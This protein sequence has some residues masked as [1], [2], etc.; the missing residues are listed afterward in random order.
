VFQ[1]N[2]DI[3]TGSE[4]RQQIARKLMTKIVNL[5]SVKLE[6]GSPMINMYL[7]GNP[8]HY[9]SHNFGNCYWQA[10]VTTARSSWVTSAATDVSGKPQDEAVKLSIVKQ[11]KWIVGISPV[12]DYIWRPQELESLSLYDWLGN[13][14]HEKM[15]KIK[16]RA[17]TNPS[18]PETPQTS[19][20]EDEQVAEKM[21][22]HGNLCHLQMIIH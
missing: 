18:R 15:G 2:L 12:M 16:K 11:G 13:C 14:V 19:D 6:H 10:F 9:C 3:I 1:K 21:I 8:D 20:D 22:E 17:D 4:S 5:L 7:L